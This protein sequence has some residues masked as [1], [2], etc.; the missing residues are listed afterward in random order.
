MDITVLN[1]I[2]NSMGDG[3]TCPVSISEL[4]KV[5]ELKNKLTKQLNNLQ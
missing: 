5:I 1:E 2:K 3:L 4:N